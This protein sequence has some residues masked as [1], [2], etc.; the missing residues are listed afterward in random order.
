MILNK[1][2]TPLQ[3]TLCDLLNRAVDKAIEHKSFTKQDADILLAIVAEF[4]MN[5]INSLYQLRDIIDS[6][7]LY[8]DLK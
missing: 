5:H 2:V 1:E 3:E 6:A 4:Y 7:H 8:N